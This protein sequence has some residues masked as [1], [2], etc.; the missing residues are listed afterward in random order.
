VAAARFAH[1]K[2]QTTAR[3]QLDLCET[4][5][6]SKEAEDLLATA[7]VNETE[8]F[9]AGDPSGEHESIPTKLEMTRSTSGKATCCIFIRKRITPGDREGFFASAVQDIGDMCTINKLARR[10]ATE[11]R[12]RELGSNHQE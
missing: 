1:A 5:F 9:R 2:P 3:L 6:Q 12:R 10:R 8:R 7:Q 4:L 11:G